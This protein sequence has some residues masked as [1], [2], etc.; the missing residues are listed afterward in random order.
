MLCQDTDAVVQVHVIIGQDAVAVVQVSV[1]VGQDTVQAL[2]VLYLSGYGC[3]CSGVQYI[4]IG[5]N[6][7]ALLGPC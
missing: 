5:Q 4:I 1:I 6:A 3:C 2:L 7:V